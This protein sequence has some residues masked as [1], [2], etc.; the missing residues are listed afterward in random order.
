[1]TDKPNVWHKCKWCEHEWLART[2]FRPVVCPRCKSYKWDK[3][4]RVKK[5]K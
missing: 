1:M 4:R 2:P 5:E 3:E